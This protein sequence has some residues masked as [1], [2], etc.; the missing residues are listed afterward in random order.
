MSSPSLQIANACI[1]CRRV[2]MKCRP[3]GQD[4]SKCERCTRKALDC[5][6][7][8]HRRGRKPGTKISKAKKAPAILPQ[9]IPS[10]ESP[11]APGTHI[12]ETEDDANNLQPSGLLNHQAL[13]GR[14]SLG[15]I[16]N[17]DQ[18]PAPR[19]RSRDESLE[20]PIE[21]GLITP[22]L[23]KSLFDSFITVLNPYISQLDPQFHTLPY[24]RSKSAFLLSSMLAMAAKAF[25][26]VLYMKLY[27]HAQ[28]LFSNVFRRGSKSVEIVQAILILTYWKEPQDTRVWTSVGYAIRIC[29]DLGWH[30]LAH[31]PS[32]AVTTESEVQRRERRNIERTCISLQTGRPWMIECSE[33]VDSIEEWCNDPLAIENDQLLGAFTTLRLVTSSAFPLLVTKSRQRSLSHSESA[34]LV[35]LLD[36]RIERWEKKWTEK[37]AAETEQSCHEFLI[38]FYGT[39]LRL[40]L[41]TLPL[42]GILVSDRSN[43]N[44]HIDTVWVAY[45]SALNMLQLISRFSEHV[46]FAQ[47]SIHVMTAYSAAFLV[48][49]TL[50]F[51][52][53]ISGQLE[54]TCIDTIQ[55]A[56]RVFSNQSGCISSSCILQASFLER[57]ATKLAENQTRHKTYQEGETTGLEEPVSH[58][59]DQVD[60]SGEP[61]AD[62]E[63]SSSSR[64]PLDLATLDISF[65]AQ[66]NL[67]FPFECNDMWAEMLGMDSQDVTFFP[68]TD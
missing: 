8:E 54:S 63:D 22:S 40:Q 47:D 29:M 28:D 10:L 55:Q 13:E 43:I 57:V 35:S 25:N 38:R 46:C 58:T 20:D 62:S 51:S 23:A 5:I 37:V 16:L 27:D 4:T 18:E 60:I 1:Q 32:E 49:I 30:K 2:K 44:H 11:A 15:N 66:E 34:P 14:F 42:H 53:F 9:S 7:R 45:S 17:A 24:V 31:C 64:R 61:R 36:S 65:L 68:Q 39:H 6:F 21:L 12:S 48:K 50:V 41:H 3:M 59:I 56:A 33:F 67:D 19:Q 26:H 52:D